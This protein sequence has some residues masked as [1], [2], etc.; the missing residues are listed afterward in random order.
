M[1]QEYALEWLD[2]TVYDLNPLRMENLGE[3][4]SRRIVRQVEEE[5]SRNIAYINRAVFAHGKRSRAQKVVDA[6]FTSLTNIIENAELHLRSV[7]PRIDRL[8]EAL[9]AI[10]VCLRE[11]RAFVFDRYNFLL[12]QDMPIGKIGKPVLEVEFSQLS[13]TELLSGCPDL[14]DLLVNEYE[15]LLGGGT[16]ITLRQMTYWQSLQ[17]ALFSAKIDQQQTEYFCQAELMLIQRNFNSP[18]FVTYLT[19]RIQEMSDVHRAQSEKVSFLAYI[20]KIVSQLPVMKDI[21]YHIGYQ[22]VAATLGQWIHQEIEYQN[23]VMKVNVATDP[24]LIKP[25]K[26]VKKNANKV[27][28]SLTVDQLALFF[29]AADHAKIITARSLSAIFNAVAPHLATAN[30]EDISPGSLRTKSYSVE[31]RDKEMVLEVI[32]QIVQQIEEL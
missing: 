10:L 15:L 29:K 24:A 25:G 26:Y 3:D 31:Q 21:I 7:T 23:L 9:E 2:R 8:K 16:S 6:Y 13:G 17:G 4:Q 18:A 11:V 12:D 28:C 20:N 30:K 19:Q 22:G 14:Y 27:L 1:E 32:D 5:K